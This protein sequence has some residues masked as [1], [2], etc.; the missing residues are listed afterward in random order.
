MQILSY[1]DPSILSGNF[2]GATMAGRR[3]RCDDCDYDD[4]DPCVFEDPCNNDYDI[5]G[6]CG[7]DDYDCDC[8]CEWD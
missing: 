4:G 6:H 7:C 1:G 8:H 3:R 2:N 5:P